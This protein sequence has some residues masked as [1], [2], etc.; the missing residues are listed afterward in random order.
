MAPGRIEDKPCACARAVGHTHA[1]EA[2]SWSGVSLTTSVR[3][4]VLAKTLR[5]QPRPPHS[6]VPTLRVRPVGTSAPSYLAIA[7]PVGPLR[8]LLSTARSHASNPPPPPVSRSCPVLVSLPVF[9]TMASEGEPITGDSF[10]D[11][12]K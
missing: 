1:Y 10:R 4:C 5:S 7:T 11:N 6:R 2:T 9:L 3:W 8:A 12:W